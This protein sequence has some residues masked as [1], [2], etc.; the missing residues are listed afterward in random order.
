M[1]G[2]LLQG[3]NDMGRRPTGHAKSNLQRQHEYQDNACSID[4]QLEDAWKK[5][6]WDRRNRAEQGG[7]VEWTKTYM[8]GLT[9]DDAPPPLGEEILK[10]MENAITAHSNFAIAMGRGAGKSAYSITTSIYALVTGL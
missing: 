6:D 4:K 5:V 9:L 3:E 1:G 8:I 10:K 7:L 2:I